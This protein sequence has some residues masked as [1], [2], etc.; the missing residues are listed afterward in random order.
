MHA[1]LAR[2]LEAALLSM[3]RIAAHRLLAEA[4]RAGAPDDVVQSIVVPALEA[5]GDG[6][7]D[8]SVALAQVYMGGRICEEALDAIFSTDAPVAPERPLCAIVVLDDY[9]LLGKRIVL[10]GLRATGVRVVDYGRMTVDQTVARVEDD[11]I[12]ILFVSVLMLPAALRVRELTSE[13]RKRNLPVRVVVGGAS[14]LLDDQLWREVGADAMGRSA[15]DAVRMVGEF[16]E[17]FS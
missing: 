2:Q 1:L 3:D 15:S 8:G 17:D 6:W 13:L 10:S 12:D 5:I 7:E 14:F 9:H 11:G 4:S 16:R